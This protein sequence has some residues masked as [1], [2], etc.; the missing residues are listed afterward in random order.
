[1]KIDA[2]DIDAMEIE[3]SLKD[4]PQP[5]GGLRR[6][7]DCSPQGEPC[8]VRSGCSGMFHGS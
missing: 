8:M 7:L 3:M 1:M 2:T 6:N 5:D 4:L